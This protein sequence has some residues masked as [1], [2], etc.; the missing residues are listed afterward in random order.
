MDLRQASA[1]ID[2]AVSML[3]E[4]ITIADDVDYYINTCEEVVVTTCVKEQQDRWP[5]EAIH[6]NIL[7]AGCGQE[8][9]A[10]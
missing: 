2:L 9:Y 7:R 10:Q 5:D 3:V 6:T 1:A 4:E 8:C